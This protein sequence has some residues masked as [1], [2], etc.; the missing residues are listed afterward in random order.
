MIDTS[1]KINSQS[2]EDT[3]VGYISQK[4][5]LDK[6]TSEKSNNGTTFKNKSEKSETEKKTNS[7]KSN[8]DFDCL[9]NSE[10]LENF[11]RTVG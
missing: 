11:V 8:L 6:N 5:I 9:G 3:H 7:E 10:R 1:L 2:L 4:Y